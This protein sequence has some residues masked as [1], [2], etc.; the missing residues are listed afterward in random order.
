[1]PHVPLSVSSSVWLCDLGLSNETST[2]G[3]SLK[4]V[5]ISQGGCELDACQIVNDRQEFARVCVVMVVV[6]VGGAVFACLV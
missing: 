5:M 3:L 4:K 1:M 2:D 6:V